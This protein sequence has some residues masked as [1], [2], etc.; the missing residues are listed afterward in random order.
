MTKKICETDTF[1]VLCLCWCTTGKA[2]IFLIVIIP[3]LEIQTSIFYWSY[4]NPTKLCILFKSIHPVNSESLFH[5]TTLNLFFFKIY[6][7]IYSG[8]IWII[9]LNVTAEH[10][11][12]KRNKDF[13][14]LSDLC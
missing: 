1:T 8:S 13:A 11:V 5:A 10:S 9:R 6:M 4:Q 2:A 7:Y 3:V 14:Y 12:D